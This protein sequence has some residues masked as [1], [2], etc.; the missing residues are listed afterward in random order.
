M[1]AEAWR[2]GGGGGGGGTGSYGGGGDG[3]SGDGAAAMVPRLLL[4]GAVGFP[5]IH[6]HISSS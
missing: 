4:S 6:L 1:A 3:G 2:R 5:V